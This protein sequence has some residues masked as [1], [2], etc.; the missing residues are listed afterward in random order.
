MT[1]KKL[2]VL[3]VEDSRVMQQLLVEILRS[4]PQIEIAAVASDGQEALAALVNHKPDLV[5]MD[6]NLPGMN[7]FEVTRRIMETEPVPVVIVS[8]V[9]LPDEVA[10]TFKAVEAGAVAVLGKP[11]G[12][13]HP[14]HA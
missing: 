13:G 14:D 6:V 9:W 3:I 4:D 8:A 11:C 12:P 2:R 10:T 7:G 5:T 1:K